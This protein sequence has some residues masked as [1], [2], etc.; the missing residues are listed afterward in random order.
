MADGC[1]DTISL[2]SPEQTSWR[3]STKWLVSLA[4]AVLLVSGW[5]IRLLLRRPT[6]LTNPPQAI[7]ISACP[8]SAPGVLHI[9]DD[10]WGIRGVR[11]DAPDDVFMV[12]KSD[13]DMLPES[14]YVV[15]LK[16][17]NAKIVV[18]PDEADFK[19]LEIAYPVFSEHAEKR[20]IRDSTGRVFGT[21]SSDSWGYLHT[22]E[23]RRYARFSMEDAV[24]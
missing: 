1:M 17:A 18:S 7:A 8:D 6:H 3:H 22:G 10:F 16:S 5:A 20:Y 23:R 9:R 19:D 2:R 14:L 11:F 21:D 15:T 12:S 24:G 13:R 4:V